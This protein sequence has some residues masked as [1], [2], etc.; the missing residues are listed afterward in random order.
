ME[1]T[2]TRTMIH[3][4]PENGCLLPAGLVVFNFTRSEP[5]EGLGFF[6]NFTITFPPRC[7]S[8]PALFTHYHYSSNSTA[9]WLSSDY[10]IQQTLPDFDPHYLDIE[11]YMASMRQYR[12]MSS[13]QWAIQLPGPTWKLR[14]QIV[15][16]V[17]EAYDQ[18][19]KFDMLKLLTSSSPASN[20]SE[21]QAWAGSLED[22]PPML[23][24]PGLDGKNVFIADLPIDR[25]HQA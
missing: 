19:K 16:L 24:S 13:C 3:T 17:T 23:I 10:H 21:V 4:K 18:Y 8:S 5:D 12:A 2:L 1:E 9:G 20:V 7:P 22:E 11:K 15:M 14:V 6:A 25:Q